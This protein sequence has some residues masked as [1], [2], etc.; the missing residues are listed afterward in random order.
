MTWPGIEP[1]SPGLLVKCCSNKQPDPHSKIH[2]QISTLLL[3]VA[4]Y[5]SIGHISWS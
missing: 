3:Q 2:K 1:R 4:A 5:N